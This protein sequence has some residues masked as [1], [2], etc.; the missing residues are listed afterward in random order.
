M[1][2]PPK[3]E[4]EH[5]MRST[6]SLS[7]QE[8]PGHPGRREPF[9]WT[10]PRNP[11]CFRAYGQTQGKVGIGTVCVLLLLCTIP[12]QALELWSDPETGRHILL[13]TTLK[14]TGL[15]ARN[16]DDRVLFPERRSATA[17]ARTRFDLDLKLSDSVNAELAYEHRAR[18]ETHAGGASIGGALTPFAP[19][20]W[21]MTSLDWSLA[22]SE[23]RFAW[24]HEID[25]ALVSVHPDWGRVTAGR[26]AIGFGRGVLFSAVD[27]FA[28]FSPVEVDREWRRGVDALR[29]EYRTTPLSA[30]EVVGVFGDRWRHSALLGRFS[31]YVGDVDGELIV[32]KR[33]RDA[34]LAATLSAAVGGA[35]VHGEAALFRTPEDQPDGGLFGR[36]DLVGKAVLGA[37]YT[38]NVGNGLTLVAEY[39]YSGFGV[40]DMANALRRFR[41][42]VFTERY[43]RGDSQILG[44][45]ALAGQ[46]SYPIGDVV[47]G[48]LLL[49]QSPSDG[50]GLASPGLLWT[51]TQTT[52]ITVN[53]FAPWGAQPRRGKLRS[54]YGTSPWSLYSQASVYF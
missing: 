5:Q 36:D 13:N 35:A 28:P 12:A 50:S 52:T 2:R 25:R 38:F 14:L 40:T 34:M 44:R 47:T 30:I 26:Q 39:H 18:R 15:A 31:G 3:A 21:R 24:R 49:L 9:R 48:T 6:Q 51:P 53:A 42:P 20:P 11:R 4:H 46:L 27:V 10:A 33:A 1:A 37:S 19:A 22:H 7:Y 23:D 16:P 41:D 45:H 8:L 43:Q 32:G 54:E 29:V 17:L